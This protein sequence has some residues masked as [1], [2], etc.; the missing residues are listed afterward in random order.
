LVKL[1]LM[2]AAGAAAGFVNGLL[3]TGGG[4]VLVLVLGKIYEHKENGGGKDVFA[5]TVAVTAVL[6]VVSLWG[7]N[8][9]GGVNLAD[10][11][12]Y[13][14]AAVPGGI[15]GA[16]LLNKL[17]TEIMKTVFACVTVFGGLR[18]AGVI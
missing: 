1:F 7:Y 18:M 10:G 2:L 8:K 3:G 13:G 6:S 4:I 17:D 5:L 16:Y 12:K 11:L 14:S 9:N 15:F